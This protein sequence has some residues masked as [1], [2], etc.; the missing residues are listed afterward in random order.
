MNICISYT[1]NDVDEKLEDD[2]KK[3]IGLNKFEGSGCGADEDTDVEFDLYF[4]IDSKDLNDIRS[5][6]P[7]GVKLGIMK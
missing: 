4:E 3:M 2:I 1:A 7:D 5:K 6:L